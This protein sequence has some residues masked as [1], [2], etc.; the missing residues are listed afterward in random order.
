MDVLVCGGGIVGL[1]AA[2]ELSDR[3]ADVTLCERGSLGGGSTARAA[4]GIRSQFSTRINV[5]LSLAS[6]PVWNAFEER[7]GVDI[8]LR[9][10]GYLFLART[11][12]TADRFRENVSMQRDLGAATELLTPAEAADYCPGIDPESFVAATYNPDDGVAD[13]N[14]AVQG[15]ADAAREAG[16]DIRTKAAVT[17][18]HRDG[19]R[20]V[21]VD[22]S[23]GGATDRETV[24]YVVN[25]AGAWATQLGDLAGVELPI[26]SRRRQIA[27]VEPS[28]PVPESAPLTIDLDTGSYFR[29]ERDGIALV[30][31]HFDDADPDA[32][33]DGYDEGMDIDWAAE[34]VEQVGTYTDYFGPETRIRRGWAGLYAVTPDHHPIIEQSLPGLVTA[35]GFSGHG[36]QHAPATGQVVADLILDSETDVT[37]VSALVRER[38]ERGQAIVE[39]SVA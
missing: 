36:F 24:D 6:K 26:A 11:D 25:A 31:G 15:Y 33:P 3:G 17:D 23:D 39:R 16:V 18:I 19:N 35:A 34:A 1:A 32:D 22:V 2:Y 14:L 5:E 37:D 29:P 7:F 13:P 28:T 9:K 27:V 20:V 10:N 38:F 12:T 4:G 21:G 8:G 30:G